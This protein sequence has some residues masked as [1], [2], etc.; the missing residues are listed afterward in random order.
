MVFHS[1]CILENHWYSLEAISWVIEHVW[2]GCKLDVF[3]SYFKVL[4]GRN[5]ICSRHIWS[6]MYSYPMSVCHCDIQL[7]GAQVLN[8]ECELAGTHHGG[9]PATTRPVSWPLRS[10]TASSCS[11]VS[12]LV[13]IGKNYP[14]RNVTLIVKFPSATSRVKHKL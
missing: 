3:R 14:D 6:S 8:C 9:Q 12:V 10:P 4:L 5:I 1:D 2:H 11:R 13:P 7:K